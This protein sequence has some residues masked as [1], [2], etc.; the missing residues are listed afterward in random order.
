MNLLPKTPQINAEARRIP[1]NTGQN[2]P[3]ISNNLNPFAI[4][5][6]FF[7]LIIVLGTG[8]S[9]YIKKLPPATEEKPVQIRSTILE[10]SLETPDELR[11][12]ETFPV[13]VSVKN[14]SD[15]EQIIHFEVLNQTLWRLSNAEELI[16]EAGSEA[17]ATLNIT[18]L[19]SGAWNFDL[20]VSTGSGQ[21]QIISRALTIR[22]SEL[23]AWLDFGDAATFIVPKNRRL[24]GV[25]RW[26]SN[27]AVFAPRIS[28]RTDAPSLI[29]SREGLITSFKLGNYLPANRH[30]GRAISITLNKNILPGTAFS[31]RDLH[32][33][34]DEEFEV[35]ENGMRVAHRIRDII[36]PNQLLVSAQIRTYDSRGRLI[37]TLPKPPRVGE[38]STYW[39]NLSLDRQAR[40]LEN[41]SVT[42]TLPPWA[43]PTGRTFA[44]KED[45][46]DVNVTTHALTWRRAKPHPRDGRDF[47][48]LVGIEI[49]YTPQASE[50]GRFPNIGSLEAV[51]KNE[52]ISRHLVSSS[53]ASFKASAIMGDLRLDKYAK[54]NG[55]IRAD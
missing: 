47:A 54:E 3:E 43:R 38:T 46:I 45:A 44:S 33:Y 34:M 16:I 30:A 14:T 2:I 17:S 36:D 27:A 13:V 29:N 41:T 39:L 12:G 5:L 11:A 40:A 51:A 20:K 4:F 48:P 37:T 23:S 55:V 7:V 9:F 26:R 42:V 8:Y 1:I 35:N 6:A 22:E 52:R 21:E 19:V 10:P 24:Y 25:I 18:A 49:E 32:L 15:A 50:V 31:Y 28:L 53:R